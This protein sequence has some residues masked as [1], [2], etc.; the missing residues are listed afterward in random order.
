[1]RIRSLRRRLQM[2]RASTHL[3]SP[4]HRAA[5]TV[6]RS[7]ALR[8]AIENRNGARHGQPSATCN[9]SRR[10]RCPRQTNLRQRTSR[11]PRT[12]RLP[13]TAREVSCL[14]HLCREKLLEIRHRLLQ[15][16]APG[17]H[18]FVL[19]STDARDFF[20]FACTSRV[21]NGSR[22]SCVRWRSSPCA[23]AFLSVLHHASLGACCFARPCRRFAIG[24]TAGAP[25]Q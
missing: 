10:P 5:P 6:S 17:C 15:P 14:L 3:R 13:R 2:I 1:M 19:L 20:D 23:C 18:S 9:P 11:Q 12:T 24:S 16:V 8:E 21:T 4:Q 22:L 7:A 25:A